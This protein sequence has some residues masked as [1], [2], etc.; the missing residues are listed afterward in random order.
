MLSIKTE[1]AIQEKSNGSQRNLPNT[2][3]NTF[4]TNG[5]GTAGIDVQSATETEEEI[6]MPKPPP[7]RLFEM[8]EKSDTPLATRERSMSI[9]SMGSEGSSMSKMSGSGIKSESEV[10]ELEHTK[11]KL[12]EMQADIVELKRVDLNKIFRDLDE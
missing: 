11:E 6:E 7:K 5:Q 2:A 4:N 1:I 3:N 12:K 9:K 8:S 10:N